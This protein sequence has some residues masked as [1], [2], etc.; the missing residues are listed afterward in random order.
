MAVYPDSINPMRNV[1]NNFSYWYPKVKDAGIATPKSFV[2]KLPV[3]TEED[4]A[5][6]EKAWDNNEPWKAPLSMRLQRAFFMESHENDIDCIQGWLDTDVLPTLREAKLT[7]RMFVKNATF[8]NKFWAM[9]ACLVRNV[10]ELAEA[11]ATINYNALMVGAGGTDEL[12]VR[13]YIGYDR[14]NTACIYNGLP[15]RPEFRVFYDFDRHEPIFVHN[16]WETKYIQDNLYDKTDR[17][18]FE[19]ECKGIETFYNEH[20]DEVI[21]MVAKAMATVTALEGQ[22]SVDIMWDSRAK[23]YWLIDMAIAQTSAYW[24]CRPA[25]TKPAV[26]TAL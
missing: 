25:E 18:V 5:V 20:K 4:R 24:G 26:E 15:L 14:R 1:E 12:V 8:S 21:D 9:G 10:A 11:F 17:L 3:A 7:G 13:E 6:A 16:Y 23:K 2:F 22:W 19:H